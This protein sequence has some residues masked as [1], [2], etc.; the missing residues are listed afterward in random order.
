MIMMEASRLAFQKYPSPFFYMGSPSG[1]T[2]RFLSLDFQ[3]QTD[4]LVV[5]RSI[6][7]IKELAFL[8][9]RSGSGKQ[10]CPNDFSTATVKQNSPTTSSS[11]LFFS[12]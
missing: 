2:A 12:S 9:L 8:L 6:F 1:V 3:Q 5:H 4:V 10:R 7:T 11:I